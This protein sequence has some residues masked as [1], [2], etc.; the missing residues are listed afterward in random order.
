MENLENF[1]YENSN[2][3]VLR[4]DFSYLQSLSSSAVKIRIQDGV[5][6]YCSGLLLHLLFELNSKT[7]KC[8]II[9]EADRKILSLRIICSYLVTRHIHFFVS[10]DQIN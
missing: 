4:K 3:A 2:L 5:H 6:R 1:A 10:M 7:S 8:K 9:L